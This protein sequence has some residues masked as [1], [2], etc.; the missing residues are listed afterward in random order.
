M[1]NTQGPKAFN[2]VFELI[3]LELR[4]QYQLAIAPGPS[5][6]K[7]KWHKLKVTASRSGTKSDSE[8][9]IARTR[10]GYYR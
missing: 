1:N 3:A 2:E 5:S 10:Q 4:S 6:G 8:E 9:L 7:N